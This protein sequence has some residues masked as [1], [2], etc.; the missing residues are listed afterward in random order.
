MLES[1]IMWIIWKLSLI[2]LLWL[3]RDKI[4]DYITKNYFNIFL[5]VAGYGL[6]K[7]GVQEC[8]ML[9]CINIYVFIILIP[10][11]YLKLFPTQYI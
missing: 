7:I 10:S 8:A 11:F 3:L 1:W 6:T 2:H 4:C 5:V 9:F